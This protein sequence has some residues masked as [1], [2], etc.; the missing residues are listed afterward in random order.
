MSSVFLEWCKAVWVARVARLEPFEESPP[1]APETPGANYRLELERSFE[2]QHE[3]VAA[4]FRKGCLEILEKTNS[5]VAEAKMDQALTEEKLSSERERADEL[6]DHFENTELRIRLMMAEVRVVR[7][8]MKELAIAGTMPLEELSHLQQEINELK[9]VYEHREAISRRQAV[10]QQRINDE[11]TEN[12]TE[13]TTLV[14]VSTH[15]TETATAGIGIA[16][17]LTDPTPLHMYAPTL[18]RSSEFYSPRPGEM[19]ADAAAAAATTAAA[20]ATTATAA[21]NE[22][23]RTLGVQRSSQ[24]KAESEVAAGL[25]AE[26]QAMHAAVAAAEAREDVACKALAMEAAKRQDADHVLYMLQARLDEQHVSQA[27]TQVGLEATQAQ[28]QVVKQA[29]GQLVAVQQE[30]ESSDLLRLQAS[31]HRAPGEPQVTQAALQA[32]LQ[33]LR[34]KM[35]VWP[36]AS[37]RLE[38]RAL[39]SEDSASNVWSCAGDAGECGGDAGSARGCGVRANPVEQRSGGAEQHR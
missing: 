17:M 12:L 25:W 24:G 7:S 22:A 21:A 6:A 30:S 8:K 26:L 36:C 3:E 29:A 37:A 23:P 33:M 4:Q 11:L 38:L 31:Q 32:E 20:A 14:A 1:T 2:R 19:D 13:A 28:L 18:N 35:Q 10:A 27:R 39:Q 5:V 9:D 16:D 34:A 15:I